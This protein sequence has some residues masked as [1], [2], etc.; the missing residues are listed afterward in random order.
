MVADVWADW[1]IVGREAELQE[2]ADLVIH[3]KASLVLA[4]PAGVGKTRLASELA[5]RCVRAGLTAVSVTGTS[6]SVDIP[7]GAFAPL[8]P[9]LDPELVGR[10]DA[11]ADLL[12]RT[13]MTLVQAASPRRMVLI[14]DDGHSLDGASAT[15]VYQLATTTSASVIA[16][17]RTGEPAP[18]PITKLWKD[19]LAVRR[20][21]AGL[22]ARGVGELLSTVLSAPLDPSAV[23]ELRDRSDGNVLFLRE[24]VLGAVRSQTLR[25]DGG[26]WRL[27]GPLTVSDRLSELIR[28]R[29]DALT[30]DELRVLELV[31]VGEPLAITE[32]TVLGEPEVAERL[33][34]MKVLVSQ[35]EGSEL[36]VRFAHP[37]YGDVIRNQTPALRRHALA[38]SLADAVEAIGSPGRDDLLRVAVWRLEGGGGTAELMLAAAREAR[39]RY[40]F[41]L[42]ERLARAAQASDAGPE[43]D[44]LAAQLASLQGR[45]DVAEQ[46]FAT[47]TEVVRDDNLRGAVAISRIDNLAFYLGRPVEGVTAAEHAE[48][49]LQNQRWRDQIQARRSALVF[50]IRGPRAGAEVAIPLLERADGEALVWA[51]Q[52]AAFTLG[53]LG[54]I[55]EGLDVNDRGQAA[56]LK[57]D[58]PMDWYP[59]THL[60]FRCQLLAWSG[61]FADAGALANAQYETAL[62]EHSG[63]AQAWFAWHLVSMAPEQGNV[64]SAIRHGREAVVHFRELGRP[65]FMAFGLTYLAM[66]LS[67]GG[68]AEDAIETLQT[69]D[70]LGMSDYFMGVDPLQARAWTAVAAGDLP[71][72][73]RH[74]YDAASQGRAIGDFVGASAALHGLARL[75]HAR[76][77][78]ADLND[79]ASRVEGQLVRV[80]CDHVRALARAN[81]DQL[82]EVARSFEA[83][84]ANLLAAEAAADA[85]VELRKSSDY[86]RFTA[87]ER[88]AQLLAERCEGAITPALSRI[89]SPATLTRAERDAALLAAAGRSNKEIADELHL[90]VRTVE[91]RLQRAYARLGV[92]NR[93]E[94]ADA[95]DMLSGNTR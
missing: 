95:L 79:V 18:Q 39:W 14:V 66:A 8:L 35:A 55:A 49:V 51:A 56:R 54:R 19:N 74:L 45:G 1:P 83:M 63:E 70:G 4:G 84:G 68:R 41:T 31:G 92:G 64:D 13:A 37:L 94:L 21:V 6:S 82:S 57:V 52:V 33:E 87:A 36:K 28:V 89:S 71:T 48:E 65:Q 29:L 32:L 85:A 40:D 43:A 90:S 58:T 22:S 88:Y 24:L 44:L 34:R 59:W 53:R 9:P 42:A 46:Q 3:Q 47:L 61:R 67:L 69:L 25:N 5:G 27:C 50:S 30:A 26:I 10:V 75:G 78:L 38:R 72:A 62:A 91:G 11:Q 93:R 81:A 17:V 60:F 80:R 77:V 15:L 76:E 23:A 86:R 12:R 7:F 73:R 20:D 16:T 2:F